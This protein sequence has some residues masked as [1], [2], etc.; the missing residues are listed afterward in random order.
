MRLIYVV[1]ENAD[2]NVERVRIRVAKGGHAVREDKIRDRRIRSF[3]Q[4]S[5]F[6]EKADWVD[7]YDNSGAEPTLVVKKRDDQVTVYGALDDELL[8][9]LDGPL[10]DLRELLNQY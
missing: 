8:D 9:A 7:I 1:L 10:P 5:W 6:F 2:L 3:G 4:L